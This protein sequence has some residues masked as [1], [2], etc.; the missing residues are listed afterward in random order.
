MFLAVSAADIMLSVAVL[1]VV[2]DGG[3]ISAPD[4]IEGDTASNVA[5]AVAAALVG[6]LCYG[7]IIYRRRL[8]AWEVLGRAFKLTLVQ[9][10]TLMA[11]VR[12]RTDVPQGVMRMAAAYFAIY[13]CA[14]IVCRIAERL[15]LNR[16]RRMGHNLRHVVLVGDSR[17]MSVLCGDMRQSAAT[18]YNVI[19]YYGEREMHECPEGLRRLGTP[20]SLLADIS[21][22]RTPF[23]A[24]EVFFSLTSAADTPLVNALTNYCDTHFMHLYLVPELL[25]S[26]SMTFQPVRLGD[27]TLL[28]NRTNDLGRLDNRIIKRAF[29]IV[30]SLAVCLA[31][32]PFLPLLWLII[33][34]QSRGPL[35]FSQERTGLDGATFRLYKFRSMRENADA[36]RRQ[37]TAGDSRTFPFGRFMRRTSIDELPQFYNVL[38]GEM[39]VVGPRPHML[40]HTELYSRVI[41]KYMVRHFS[42][43]GITGWAQVTGYRGETPELRQME[44][45]VKRD[46]WYNDNWSFSLDMRIIIRT[47]AQAFTGSA[48]AR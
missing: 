33:N 1:L 38:R 23:L 12:L 44:E 45:R 39:S 26:F 16:V 10:L 40:Y 17:E 15:A 3:I 5:T 30:F 21:A 36:D 2:V 24:D 18:A 7:S 14:L 48:N 6:M 25:S 35:L 4:A 20:A 34:A 37:A 28:T 46:I 29:D 43:P 41:S 47:V 8:S 27:M 19:G 32:L 22:A 11:L 9:S 13:Y 42:K 31:I